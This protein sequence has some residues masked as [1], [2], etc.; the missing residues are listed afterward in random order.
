MIGID[1]EENGLVDVSNQDLTINS[2]DFGSLLS[3]MSQLADLIDQKNTLYERAK[4]FTRNGTLYTDRLNGQINVLT[5]QLL[6]TVS[7]WYTDDQGNIMFE[8]VDGGS[9][10][11]LCGAGFMI[12]NEKSEDG[13]WVFRTFGTGD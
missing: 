6:S 13:S 1:H 12:A 5:T 9:A 3:R 8:A 4:A 2:N 11:M 10:M 7:N